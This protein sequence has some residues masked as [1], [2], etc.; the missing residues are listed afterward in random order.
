MKTKDPALTKTRI[1]DEDKHDKIEDNTTVNKGTD[2]FEKGIVDSEHVNDMDNPAR[3]PD[4]R[5]QEGQA[6][7]GGVN[8][9]TLAP[10]TVG[11]AQVTDSN[12]YANVDN[13]Q[14]RVLNP[15]EKDSL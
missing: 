2:T 3:Q 5:D 7:D 13:A 10:H 14:K 15:D 8:E 1:A 9:D 12:R 4:R 6:F 11:D